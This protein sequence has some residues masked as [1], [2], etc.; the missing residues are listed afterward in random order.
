VTRLSLAR[1]LTVVLLF[2]G[3]ASAQTLDELFDDSAVHDIRLSIN[4]RDLAEL[5]ERYQ[6]NIYFPVDVRWRGVKLLNVGMRSRGMSS[7]SPTKPGLKLDFNYYVSGQ[8]FLG[9]KSLVLDNLVTDPSL[10]RERIAMRFIERMGQPAPREA[11]ARLY[12]NDRY[13]GVYAVVEPIDG[14]FLQRT[15]GERSGYLFERQYVDPYRGDDLGD[16]PAAYRRVFEARTREHEGDTILYSPIRDLF[17]LAN[18]P[19][20]GAWRESLERYVD[21][22]QFVTYVAIESFLG[23]TDGVLGTA[24]MANFYLYRAE[25]SD[26]HRFIPWDKDRTLSDTQAS[27]TLRAEENILFRNALGFTDLRRLY[28]DVLERCAQVATEGRWLE[29]EVDRLAALVADAAGEDTSKPYSNADVEA[30]WAAV[31]QFAT[32]RSTFVIQDLSRAKEGQ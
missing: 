6:E 18:Q 16:D 28:F 31:R 23:E 32:A 13:E 25:G 4:E 9:L 3:A 2:S 11:F 17:H 7:R 20:D 14:D 10:V 12:I 22:R 26:R 5:R 15:G 24:G 30:A 8:R 19:V 27:I 21:L 29:Q 1:C